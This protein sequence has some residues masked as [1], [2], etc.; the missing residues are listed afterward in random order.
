[1]SAFIAEFQY[2]KLPVSCIPV[3]ECD[4]SEED[5]DVN[6]DDEDESLTP[7]EQLWL[8]ECF[9]NCKHTMGGVERSAEQDLQKKTPECFE[10]ENLP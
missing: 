4:D 8:M 5:W 2:P 6:L 10:E 7:H 9:A 3:P 1:M